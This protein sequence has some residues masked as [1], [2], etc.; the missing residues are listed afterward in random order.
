MYHVIL[1][2][3][4]LHYSNFDS[5]YKSLQISKYCVDGPLLYLLDIYKEDV[6]AAVF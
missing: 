5:I 4:L 2:K 3:I 1:L 6:Q